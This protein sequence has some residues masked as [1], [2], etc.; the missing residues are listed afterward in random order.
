MVLFSFLT[1][2]HCSNAFAVARK[3]VRSEMK[4][5]R[6]AKQSISF[7]RALKFMKLNGTKSQFISQMARNSHITQKSIKQSL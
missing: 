3:H 1:F 7:L 2:V 4:V 6:T 5:V